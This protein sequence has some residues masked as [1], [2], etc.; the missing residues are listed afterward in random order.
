MSRGLHAV[1]VVGH[2]ALGGGAEVDVVDIV[3]AVV[4]RLPRSQDVAESD[5]VSGAGVGGEVDC[6]EHEGGG[7]GVVESGDR[8]EG[9]GVVD[10]G[11]HTDLQLVLGLCLL[12]VETQLQ[13]VDIACVARHGIDAAF[14]EDEA[15][16]AAVG[17]GAA[18][19]N[20][21][22]VLVGHRRCRSRSCR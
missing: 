9:A 15:V 3:A 14:V 16:V 6:A 19:V 17:S 11:H 8:G 18:V 22:L 2:V 20:H 4:A 5:V 12:E 13:R 7:G 10:V 1:A 21:G